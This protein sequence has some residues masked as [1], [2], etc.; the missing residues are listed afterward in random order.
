MGSSGGPSA[1]DQIGAKVT[2]KREAA[3]QV[4]LEQATVARDKAAVK[5]DAGQIMFGGR[6]GT[7]LASAPSVGSMATSG[8]TFLGS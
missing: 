2:A 1:L 8:K 6:S 7:M 5:K 3:D 4:L